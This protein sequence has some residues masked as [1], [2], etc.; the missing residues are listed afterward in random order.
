M[1]L[2]AQ[3]QLDPHQGDLTVEGN[4]VSN[5]N[6]TANSAAEEDIRPASEATKKDDNETIKNSAAEETASE[7][8]KDDNE[9]VNSVPEANEKEPASVEETKSRTWKFF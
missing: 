8:S 6:E 2:T 4:I 1:F 7:A 3:E 5:D 9:T